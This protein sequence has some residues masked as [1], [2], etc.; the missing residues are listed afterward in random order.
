MAVRF[1]LL[2]DVVAT[3]DDRPVTLGHAR[4]QCVLAAL[5]VDVN[6]AVSV[7]QLIDRVWGESPPQRARDTLY[8][9][10]YR[11]R[12]NLADVPDAAITRRS[13]GY[14]LAVDEMAVDLHRFRHLRDEARAER[15]EDDRLALFDKALGLWRGDPFSGLDAFWLDT[16][17]TDLEQEKLTAE[18]ERIDAALRV[19]HH[20]E[21]LADLSRLVPGQPLNERLAGQMLLALSGAGRSAEAL[22]HYRRFRDLLVE[23]LG[24]E[25]SPHLQ[26]LH[27][28]ILAPEVA[29]DPPQTGSPVPRQLPMPSGSFT[30]RSDDLAQLDAA[31]LTSGGTTG[32]AVA[33]SGTGGIGKT[34]LALH[35]AATHLDRYPDGQLFVNLSGFH[36]TEPPMT[37]GG[38]VR[39]ILDALDVAP[40]AVPADL[41]SQIGL[42]RSLV[43]DRRMLIVLD[44]ARD[45]DQ[46]RPLLPGS[47]GC[48]VLVTSRNQMSGL[49]ATEGL[50][51]LPLGCLSRDEALNLLAGRL[52][53]D[54]LSAE[55]DA[56]GSIVGACAGLPLALSIVAARAAT[57]PAL[58][59]QDLA[60]ELAD[61][62]HGLDALAD[63]DAVADV[64]S[65]IAASY[66]ALSAPAAALFRLF[67]LYA[68]PDVSLP[69]VASL[70]GLPVQQVR[71]PLD[72]LLGAH[73]VDLTG[74]DRYACHDLL[75]AYAGELLDDSERASAVR[76]LYDHWLHGAHAAALTIEPHR[77]RIDLPPPAAGTAVA[78]F[79]DS[80]QAQLW[81]DAER[82]VL[83]AAIDQAAESDLDGHAWRL[84]WA[85][86]TYLSR[87]SRWTDLAS[88]QRT[89]VTAARRAGDLVGE[90]HGHRDLGLALHQLGE[91]TNGLG[92]LRRAGEL[93]GR[94]GDL[95]GEAYV[96]LYLGWVH[97]GQG[98]HREALE[99]D[100]RALVLFGE[101]GHLVGRAKAL[102]AIG[103][104]HARLGDNHRAADHCR[105]AL[106]LHE[107]VGNLTGAA[108]TWDS[109]GYVHHQRG[110]SDEA[111]VC[112]RRALEL[113]E[114]SDDRWGV[115]ET[116]TRLG[117]VLH[118]AGDV[119]AARGT[120]LRALRQLTEDNPVEIAEL[121]RRLDSAGSP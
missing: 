95:A 116:L 30:G 38:A 67:A 119:E 19:G 32:T 104:D 52:G 24:V 97:E 35:W 33:V 42:Y 50:R 79:T 15:S 39:A 115:A 81:L 108:K 7:D 54:R 90:A 100:E 34:W 99:C 26:Q 36:P 40:T 57:N 28:S 31:L 43:A 65:V 18:L 66:R 73:L 4:Q 63:R 87:L 48:A 23:E 121:R 21:I 49:V 96:A 94:L 60:D 9:Y 56:A 91:V 29:A 10:L 51:P 69:A 59:L 11:L 45:P 22:E 70:V 17:R 105:R 53:R 111:C 16:V 92:H 101:V 58:S 37:P 72:E 20:D 102:N 120:W 114:Q 14:L 98:Q 78:S 27:R 77:D 76:R 80:E 109:L 55:A 3:V 41:D 61:H 118:D 8:G 85:V 44:D 113:Y 64:R 62:H 71:E 13:G 112:Y 25:P 2:G 107:E 86:A 68:G 1:G 88:A 110:D 75:R 82:L 93:F 6:R 46:V 106:A 74:P 12:R 89:A 117:D 5:L 83:L 103:W 47:A 84:A